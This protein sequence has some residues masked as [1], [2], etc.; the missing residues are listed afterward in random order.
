MQPHIALEQTEHQARL[1]NL[2]AEERPRERLLT[3]GAERVST[4]ELLAIVLRTGGGGKNA[5]HVAE[6]L[7]SAFGGLERMA[8]ASALE[9]QKVPGI[10]PAKAAEIQAAFELGRRLTS[11]T[12]HNPPRIVAPADVATLLMSEMCLLKREQLR[13]VLLDTRNRVLNI[14]LLY[15]GSL[16]SSPVRVCEPFHYAL[17]EN[18]AAIIIVHNHPSGDPSPSAED[19][20]VTRD[21]AKA[22]EL[23][24]IELLDHVI[25]GNQRYVSLKEQG[26][27]FDV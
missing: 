17:I 21:I 5:L 18:A 23:L 11:I 4:S 12:P 3:H 22:G 26:L 27:G 10:G 25:I 24:G 7:L 15:I 9:L 14:R 13:V 2:P 6:Q 8:R 1:C 16:N 20:R 19:I